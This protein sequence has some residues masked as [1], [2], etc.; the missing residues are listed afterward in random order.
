[1]NEANAEALLNQEDVDGGLI[2]TASLDADQFLRSFTPLPTKTAER[3]R[4]QGLREPRER[5]YENPTTLII[6]DGFALGEDIPGNAVQAPPP[7]AGLSLLPVPLA[8]W[9]PPA[10]T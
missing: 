8:S 10:W 7:P 9:R 6:M 3:H 1:M 4:G 2:G 5:F